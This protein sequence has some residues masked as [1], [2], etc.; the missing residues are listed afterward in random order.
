MALIEHNNPI[1]HKLNDKLTEESPRPYLGLS[2]I[3]NSCHRFLQHYHY[4]TFTSHHSARLKRL[5]M[6]GHDAE[7]KM[8]AD[9]KT[10]GIMVDGQQE[11]IIGSAGHWKG[12]TDGSGWLDTE[13]S[14]K[15][16]VEFKTHN[17][18]SFNDLKKKKMKASKP[19]HYGQMQAY[20]GYKEYT[21]GL[22]M[23]L[24]KNTSEYYI[25]WVDFD[26]DYFKDSKRKEVEVIA[27]D[28]MLPRIGND[29][30]TWFECK[31]CDA[32]K[33]CFGD[34]EVVKSCRSCQNVDV[35]PDGQWACVHN[36]QSNGIL[37]LT[38]GMQ[39]S[40]CDNYDLAEM[41]KEV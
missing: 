9:L 20:M 30:K 40:A 29:N 34:K 41:F 10:V 37:G 14:D 28:V 13:A 35:L 4:W 16:L 19:T 32:R 8:I 22:Y 25:E 3:G 6:V 33:V 36:F 39:R 12:H 15:F 7:D 1:L 17:D 24:N 5:F 2:Q 38:E 21:K 11:R 23:A 18:K 26:E 31:F 27:S